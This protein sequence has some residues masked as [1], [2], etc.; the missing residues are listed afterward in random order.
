MLDRMVVGGRQY[1]VARRI[2]GAGWRSVFIVATDLVCIDG[3]DQVTA[4]ELAF[5][6]VWRSASCRS[7]GVGAGSRIQHRPP[8]HRG[9]SSEACLYFVMALVAARAWPERSC[10]SRD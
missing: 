9:T 6:A 4:P 3:R 8:S 5:T 1:L 7:A 10:A 2:G